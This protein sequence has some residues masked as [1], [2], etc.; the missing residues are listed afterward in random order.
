MVVAVRYMQ[1]HLLSTNWFS[2]ILFFIYRYLKKN[3]DRTLWHWYRCVIGAAIVMH[4][5]QIQHVSDFTLVNNFLACLKIEFG[6]TNLY[7]E[8]TKCQYHPVAMKPPASYIH[9]YLLM[10]RLA[11]LYDNIVNKKVLYSVHDLNCV[12][13]CPSLTPGVYSLNM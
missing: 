9:Y 4:L 12:C 7:V 5:K 3:V 2:S 10:C 6:M 11:V 1:F 13:T 8:F